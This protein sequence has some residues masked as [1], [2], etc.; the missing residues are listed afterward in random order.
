MKKIRLDV[1]LSPVQLAALKTIARRRGISVSAI[2]RQAVDAIL[3]KY[4]HGKVKGD[5]L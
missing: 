3:K 2:G 5:G 4:N 1:R